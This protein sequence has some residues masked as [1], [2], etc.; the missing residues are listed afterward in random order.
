MHM[1]KILKKHRHLPFLLSLGH[2]MM[3]AQK[4]DLLLSLYGAGTTHSGLLAGTL[5]TQCVQDAFLDSCIDL[6][7]HAPP[8]PLP[9]HGDGVVQQ[10]PGSPKP[11]V[12]SSPAVPG[13]RRQDN[14]EARHMI[15]HLMMASTSRPWKP[16]S[17]NLVAST[18]RQQLRECDKHAGGYCQS[19]ECLKNV[20]L[21]SITAIADRQQRMPSA[22]AQHGAPANNILH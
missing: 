21:L 3:K 10:V 15:Q 11:A 13:N 20:V 2:N 7:R 22:G 1:A 14:A 19:T 4:E 18:C 9:H 16:T 5:A 12:S 8:L 6:L 17:V